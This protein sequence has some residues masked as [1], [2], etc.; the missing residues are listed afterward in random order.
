[1][2]IQIQYFRVNKN[3]ILEET[4]AII[5]NNPLMNTKH[6]SNVSKLIFLC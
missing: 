4:L 5:G 6:L 1:M 3:S 2:Y